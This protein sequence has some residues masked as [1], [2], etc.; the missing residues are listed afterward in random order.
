MV[1]QTITRSLTSK[2]L[3]FHKLVTEVAPIP[4]NVAESRQN[5]LLD[6][7]RYSYFVRVG[8]GT[9]KSRNQYGQNSD[10][11]YHYQYLIGGTP[12]RPVSSNSSKTQLMAIFLMMAYLLTVYLVIV[13]HHYLSMILKINVGN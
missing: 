12:M 9:Q 8:S 10:V 6:K 11:A 7:S 5:G 3:R 2:H 13:A 4:V 1:D